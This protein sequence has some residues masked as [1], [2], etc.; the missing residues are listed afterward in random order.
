MSNNR[1]MRF[2]SVEVNMALYGHLF[3]IICTILL[4][5]IIPL[6]VYYIPSNTVMHS[7][8]APIS[9]PSPLSP[10]IISIELGGEY[11]ISTGTQPAQ[12]I[13]LNYLKKMLSGIKD[14]KHLSI[15]LKANP[16]LQYSKVKE[17]VIL[18]K[19]MGIGQIGL[20]I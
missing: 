1:G 9:P 2:R 13:S 14:R 10:I 5:T 11:F 7:S 17:I 15:C 4:A 16:T 3:L 20:V 12:S 8:S 6:T 19:S 18:L